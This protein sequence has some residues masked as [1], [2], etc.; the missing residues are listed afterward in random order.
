M[1]L[2]ILTLATWRLT[3]LLVN[4]AGPFDVFERLRYAAGVRYDERSERYGT[5][6]VA[7]G[8]ICVW[9]VS[10]WVGA[11]LALGQWLAPGVVGWLALPFALSAGA[12]V[13][14]RVV[15]R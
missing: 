5:N 8:L 3:T 2:L 13:V 10:V 9:C 6:V 14:E 12:L 4:E 15:A 1:T 7:R 11:L